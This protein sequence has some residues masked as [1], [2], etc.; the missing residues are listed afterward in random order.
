MTDTARLQI[1]VASTGSDK[2]TSEL[3]RIV[4]KGDAA[5]RATD[6][7][8]KNFGAVARSAITTAAALAG[9]GLGIAELVNTAREFEKLEA[10][11]KTATGSAENATVAFD[12]IKDFAKNTPYDLAQ[13][14][15]SF[16]KL[17]NYGL[18]PS[19]RALY[20]YGNTASA[21]GKDMSQMIEAVADASTGEF[22]RLKEFGIKA[23]KEGD[24]VT[25]TFRGI[26][27]EV[28]NNAEEIENYLIRLG[29]NNFATAM[30][31]RMSTLDGAMANL[32]D[33]WSQ[34]LADVSKAGVGDAIETSVRQGTAALE[35]L[36]SMFQSGEMAGYL[37]AAAGVWEQFGGDIQRTIEIA[38]EFF[39]DAWKDTLGESK[40][41]GRVFFETIAVMGGNTL[42]T[43][44][45]IGTE[46]GGIAA[47][48]SAVAQ[49]DFKGAAAIGEMMKDDAVKARKEIDAW[50]ESILKGG[51]AADGTATNTL[52]AAIKKAQQK[53]Q[54]W[55]REKEAAKAAGGD[56]LAGNKVGGGK[57]TGPSEAEKKASAQRAKDFQKLVESLR[58]EEEEINASYK[59]RNE[60]ILAHTTEGSAQRLDLMKRSTE[61]YNEELRRMQE[62]SELNRLTEQLK[63]EEQKIAD[64][65]AR[66]L[67]LIRQNT[68]EGAALR[69]ELEQRAKEQYDAE[70]ADAN[71]S[72]MSPIDQ[73]RA[74]L[75]TEEEE[76]RASYERRAAIIRD[77]TLLSETEKQDIQKRLADQYMKQ[78]QQLEA[79]RTSM[80][81]QNS[82]QMFEALAGIAETAKG[83]Q[84]GVYKAMFAVSK[85]FSLADAIIK[86]QAGIANAAALPFPMNLGAMATVASQTAGIISTI[87]GANFSG[88]YDIGGLIPPGSVGLVGE[89]GA[90]L[91]RG[92][93]VVTGRKQTANK[94]ATAGGSGGP[95]YNITNAPV[96]NI[97]SSTDRAQVEE[98]VQ[99][100][101]RAGNMQLE[102]RLRRK[103]SLRDE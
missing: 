81:L 86:I 23:S 68:E 13:V 73:I 29:E 84:S 42:Y 3:D 77:S 93:A 95:V 100:G 15:D 67:E 19:E 70:L 69:A 60:L 11:L 41:A 75:M 76:I 57:D 1:S 74:S 5:E 6:G 101:V 32:G 22:E 72:R 83:K 43:L 40:T 96:I 46:I 102:D 97:D 56:R 39:R 79:A 35:E 82:S 9:V 85:A 52:D 89:V 49:G 98:M 16:T 99:R 24:R 14:T 78:Q 71:S 44:K 103:G 30:T 36:S 58:T 53:R 94:L 51:Q 55:E 80:T 61:Q 92:P 48:M 10:G 66:R 8:N 54:E 90:E 31:D 27:T 18:T 4:Q 65:Y 21:L 47:Q 64:S 34:L 7:L 33:A 50:T 2:A 17:V 62:G 87:K 63:D 38:V 91:V 12:A 20:S 88:A 26:K 25:F 59:K 45:A 37:D 28:K